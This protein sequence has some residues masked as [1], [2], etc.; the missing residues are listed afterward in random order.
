[1]KINLKT[2]ILNENYIKKIHILMLYKFK[3]INK[4]KTKKIKTQ[5]KN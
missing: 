2:M 4:K 5:K 3:I 1:M